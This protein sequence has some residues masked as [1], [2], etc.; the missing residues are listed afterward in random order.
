[1]AYDFTTASSQYLSSPAPVSSVPLTIACWFNAK[2]TTT[3]HSLVALTPDTGTI[4]RRFAL[5][6]LNSGINPVRF[7]CS[8]TDG[9]AADTTTG[10]TANN[11]FHACG[12]AA[13][14]T[15]ITAYINGG[16]SSSPTGTISPSGINTVGIGARYVNGWSSF[17][18]CRIAEVGIWNVALT[19]AE[20]ASLAK[21]MT[22]DKIRPQSL[23]FYTPLV[24]NLI[25]Q[26]GGLTI[27]NTNSA[28][29]TTHP[30][31]YA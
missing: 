6:G 9:T 27:T 3:A 26:K 29:V 21:G 20:I 10:F 12:V 16:S 22:C 8:P 7:F 30:R 1:M 13:S 15:S 4:D 23:V 19:Q 24:R 11:W 5:I 2:N 31:V 17:A 28:T 18:D 14:S 25:D